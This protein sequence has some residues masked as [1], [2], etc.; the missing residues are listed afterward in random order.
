MGE[1]G[2]MSRDPIQLDVAVCW[3]WGRSYRVGFAT[4]EAAV[5]FVER[6]RESCALGEVEGTPVP[7]RYGRLLAALYPE[8]DH[9]LSLQLCYGPGHYPPDSAFE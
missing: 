6:K 8:C 9:G 2:E 3:N 5:D 4:E 7:S 1:T